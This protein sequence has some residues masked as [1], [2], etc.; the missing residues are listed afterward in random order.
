MAEQGANRRCSRSRHLHNSFKNACHRR[1]QTFRAALAERSDTRR[2]RM[3][4]RFAMRWLLGL[5]VVAALASVAFYSY[6][7]GVAHGVMQSVR[8]VEAPATPGATAVPVV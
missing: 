4:G 8:V 1:C 5:V 6:N 2:D 3:G 7:M